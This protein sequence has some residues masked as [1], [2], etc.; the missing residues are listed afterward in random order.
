MIWTVIKG[1]VLTSVAWFFVYLFVMAGVEFWK[2]RRQSKRPR[3]RTFDGSW[4]GWQMR[5]RSKRVRRRRAG[6]F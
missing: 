2:L 4:K 3:T 1:D 5:M 6:R